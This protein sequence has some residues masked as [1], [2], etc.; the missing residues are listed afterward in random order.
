MASLS[1][2]DLRNLVTNKRAEM[3][4]KSGKNNAVK[5]P[6]GK[7][8]WRVL[9]GWRAAEPLVFFHDFAQ[10]WIKDT[11]GNVK[12]VYVCERDTYGRECEIC[13]MIGQAIRAVPDKTSPVAD[14]LKEMRAK[15]GILVNACRIDGGDGNASKPVL[16]NLAKSA[17]TDF[18][19]LIGQRADDDINML[20]L[21]KGRDIIIERRGSGLT[22]E[23][24]VNDAAKE[25]K[26]SESVMENLI[27]IDQWIEA[28]RNKGLTKGLGLIASTTRVWLGG[29]VTT[30]FLKSLTPPLAAALA[31]PAPAS[32]IIDVEV[33]EPVTSGI[34][35]AP[36][37]VASAIALTEA[38]V[39]AAV[40]SAGTPAPA[41]TKISSEL[42]D[43]EELNTLL[44]KL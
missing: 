8:R 5:P 40:A 44:A 35:S 16:L 3:D 26:I 6:P 42:L 27:N 31:A 32:R 21:Q 23:Y 34:V 41:V 9:P 25:T 43:D 15:G 18:L 1:L 11:E 14:A 38:E 22:T 29:P 2:S 7:S 20:D 10:H 4:A 33:D 19:S 30:S 13:D 17:F 39:D 37:A 36:A 12:G 28:E 24:G